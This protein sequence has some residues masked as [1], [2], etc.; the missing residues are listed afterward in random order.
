MV[1]LRRKK[2]KKNAKVGCKEKES[3]TPLN[4]RAHNRMVRLRNKNNTKEGFCG[5]TL[6][7]PTWILSAGHCF[8]TDQNQPVRVFYVCVC[9]EQVPFGLRVFHFPHIVFGR[10]VPKNRGVSR[11]FS[12]SPA[13]CLILNIRFSYSSV[14]LSARFSIFTAGML[15]TKSRHSIQSEFALCVRVSASVRAMIFQTYGRPNI[16]R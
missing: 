3:L 15:R 4:T 1:R 16:S 2:Q 6:I 13:N 8:W 14:V 11:P 9:L 7:S 5:A 12:G 10:F